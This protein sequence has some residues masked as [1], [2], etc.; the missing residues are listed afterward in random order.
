MN[1]FFLDLWHDLREKRLWPVA[2]S[3]AIAIIAVPIVLA[4]PAA[5]EPAA[6]AAPQVSAE[7]QG[8]AINVSGEETL[9]RSNL[10]VFDPKNPFAPTVKM[11]SL[12]DAA[13]TSAPVDSAPKD[14]GSSGS[15]GDLA[16]GT[17]VT[18]G[19]G[20]GGGGSTG[21]GGGG[22]DAPSAP[23]TKT[24]QYTY[25]IDLTY[26]RE[27]RARRIKGFEKL[28]MLPNRESPLLLFLGV[29]AKANNAV[30]MVD[31]SLK[32]NG[33]G[34]CRPSPTDCAL[35]Y[36]GSGE[37]HFFTDGDGDSYGLRIDQI[38]KVKVSDTKS[39]RASRKS[40]PK[41]RTAKGRTERRRFLPPVL[42]DL[43][44]VASSDERASSNRRRGR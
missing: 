8:P 19:G 3:L 11:K 30:F 20:G 43:V 18:E 33:E 32:A 14:G 16:D 24:V 27:G 9:E 13:S 40:K 38:R 15:G 35:L 44:T 21:G 5:E 12:E 23:G 22:G 34:S 1:V 2:A 7:P 37:E 39:A 36:L 6:P 26:E 41:A 10:S 42:T 4:K 25:V 31:S 17:T 28:G 29:D